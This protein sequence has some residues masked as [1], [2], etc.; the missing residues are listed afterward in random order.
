MAVEPQTGFPDIFPIVE[1]IPAWIEW[2]RAERAE[3][4]LPALTRFGINFGIILGAACYIEGCCEYLLLK[5]TVSGRQLTDSLESR[6]LD[7]LTARISLA[8][9]PERFNEMFALVMGTKASAMLTAPGLWETVKILF[10]FRNMI[11]H[12]RSVTYSWLNVVPVDIAPTTDFSG[13]Y[14][15]LEDY[16]LAKSVLTERHHESGE[17]WPYFTDAIAD[18][19]WKAATDFVA[20]VSAKLSIPLPAKH[21][22]AQKS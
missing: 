6:L 17:T 11:A 1:C 18:H 9:G 13:G 5:S 16:L 7:E 22:T 20:E 15:K 12:G 8:T 2:Q 14:Q 21:R 4:T 3:S 10:H 19:F